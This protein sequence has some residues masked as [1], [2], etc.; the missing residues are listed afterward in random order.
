MNK[1]RGI[2]YAKG[3]GTT[4]IVGSSKYWTS[5]SLMDINPGTDQYHVDFFLGVST[6]V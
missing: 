6:V 2:N 4:A 3:F 5:F 1:E